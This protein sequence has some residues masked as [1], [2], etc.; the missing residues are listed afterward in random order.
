MG[1]MR[2][3]NEHGD[4]AVVWAETDSVAAERARLEFDRL[5][6]S[7]MLAFARAVGEPAEEATLV[8]CF[9]ADAD[10]IILTRAL[11]GG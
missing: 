9:D 6:S 11:V 8:R 4:T 7:G 1:T 2:I 3:L 10:E 5:V